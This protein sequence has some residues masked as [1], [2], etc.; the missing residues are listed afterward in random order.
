MENSYAQA[1]WQTIEK[2][3]DPKTAIHSLVALLKVHGR[4]ELMPRIARA[5]KRLT[6]KEMKKGRAQIWIARE[7]DAHIAMKESGIEEADVC[8]DETL[9][10]G[11]RLEKGETLVDASYKRYLLDMYKKATA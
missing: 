11:W 5:F 9:I 8:V 1:L 6:E 7:K 3:M 10:G 2:G 4:S